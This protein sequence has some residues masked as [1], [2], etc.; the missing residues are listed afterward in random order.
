M[1]IYTLYG[2]IIDENELF[3]I[4]FVMYIELLIIRKDQ[5]FHE[6]QKKKTIYTCTSYIHVCACIYTN[7]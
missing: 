5:H 3:V 7:R 4:Y 6:T 2:K 1:Y